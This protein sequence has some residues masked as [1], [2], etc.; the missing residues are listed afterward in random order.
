MDDGQTYLLPHLLREMDNEAFMRHGLDPV[1]GRDGLET[2]IRTLFTDIE[3]LGVPTPGARERALLTW[4]TKPGTPEGEA[5][6]WI[7]Q[8]K[9][10]PTTVVSKNLGRLRYG[11]PGGTADKLGLA[12]LFASTIALGYAAMSAKALFK[13]QTPRDPTDYRTFIAAFVQGGGAGI[14]GDLL[15]GE[16]NRY[17]RSL[18]DT[19]AGPGLG[20][21]SDVDELRARI[22]AGDDVA[23]TALRLAMN[24]APFLNLF[25]AR[26]ALDYLILYQLQEMAN[27]GYLKRREKTLLKEQGQ[28]FLLPKPSSTIPS[29]GGGRIFEGLR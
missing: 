21:V 2:A 11:N 14:Y 19:I 15:F 22:M 16:T 7:M 23:A 28:T 18:L 17:G 29:G 3:E 8:F 12:M 1:T 4:G 5:L 13:G 9:Q 10:F 26:G 25:Y 27:P 6:R 24:Q 20:L